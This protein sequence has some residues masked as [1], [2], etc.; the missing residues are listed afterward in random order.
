MSYYRLKQVDLDGSFSLSKTVSVRIADGSHLSLYPMPVLDEL[1][2][3][4]EG[5]AALESAALLDGAG[6]EVLRQTATGERRMPVDLSAVEPGVYFLR[7]EFED[8]TVRVE[9]VVVTR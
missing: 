2:I 8:R 3:E 7:A 5:R 9:K 6:R 1:F 4:N